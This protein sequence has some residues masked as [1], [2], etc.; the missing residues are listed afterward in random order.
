MAKE[1]SPTSQPR[2][3][4]AVDHR[5]IWPAVR[6]NPVG[7]AMFT[8][9]GMIAL[10]GGMQGTVSTS[11][12]AEVWGESMTSTRVAFAS[13]GLALGMVCAGPFGRFGDKCGN[14]LACVILTLFLTMPYVAYLVF[15]LT[16]RGLW[17]ASAAT[18]LPGLTGMTVLGAPCQYALGHDIVVP[19]DFAVMTPLAFF[20]A[21]F[22]SIVG[23]YVAQVLQGR[24]GVDA[25]VWFGLAVGAFAM[26]G[27]SLLPVRKPGSARA[28]DVSTNDAGDAGCVEEGGSATAQ[29]RS[30]GPDN[31][32]SCAVVS[33]LCFAVSNPLMLWLCMITMLLC[34]SEALIGDVMP[35]FILG[36]LGWLGGDVDIQTSSAFLF[37][38]SLTLQGAM[39][40]AC[41]FVSWLSA[42]FSTFSV[43]VSASLVAV[44]M[45]LV[46]PVMLMLPD[47]WFAYVVAVCIALSMSAAPPTTSLVPLIIPPGQIGEAMGAL[48][49]FKC[50]SFL[51]GNLICLFVVPSLQKSGIDH[52]LW[53]A[54]P[55]CSLC[56]FGAVP[57]TL[58]L[59][60]KVEEVGKAE[61]RPEHPA[62]VV[63]A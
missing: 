39:A 37:D 46:P 11:I 51:A 48:G 28:L 21:N 61:L 23:T 58:G 29:Q 57:L 17:V 24:F 6:R 47:Q 22:V 62:K 25:V 33:S 43:L 55:V 36:C 1:A 34:A 31:A 12:A 3:A 32:A 14:R 59:R 45:Q 2:L 35:Q 4:D 16:E 7:M 13:A 27:L 19:G 50:F 20:M 9:C 40:L 53:I 41:L 56:A 49:S 42:H 26:V 30:P 10:L 63:G 52:P 60:R 15:G 44:V 8:W 54:F 5:G 38:I 18:L